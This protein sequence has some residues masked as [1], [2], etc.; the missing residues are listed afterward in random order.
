MENLINKIIYIANIRLPTEKAHGLQIMKTCEA[1]AKEGIDVEMVVPDRHNFLSADPF[2]FYKV[3]KIFVV[4]KL[5]CWDLI[6]GNILGPFGFWIESWTFFRSI[7]KYLRNQGAVITFTRD[8]PMAFLLSREKRPFYYEIHTL[9]DRIKNFYKL[10]W[11]K[12][13]G[14]IVISDGLKNELIKQGVAAEKILVARDA[15]D[16]QEFK[17]VVGVS[18]NECRVKLGV[19]QDKKIAVYTGHLY[20]WKG[21]NTLAEAAERLTEAEVYLVGGTKDDVKRFKKRYENVSN[22]HIVGW[23]NRSLMPQWMKIA[24]VLVL[25]NSALQKIGAIYTSPLKLFEYMIAGKPMVV[26]DLPALREVLGDN[27]ATFFKPDDPIS[28]AEAIKEVLENSAVAAVKANAAYKN[29][30]ENYTWE[31]RAD[32]IV[33]FINLK[34]EF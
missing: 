28:L 2:N 20:G 14:L 9:P 10:V 19:P 21:A 5:S 16:I 31:K 34:S 8:L 29:V 18:T 11:Q 32:Q 25:P 12:A 4:T 30:V 7:K 6:S 15:V 24:D 17:T 33:K 13:T 23:Q 26:S 27:M 22:L 3:R 1:L